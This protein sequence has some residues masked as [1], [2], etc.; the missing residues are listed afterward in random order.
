MKVYTESRFLKQGDL[1]GRDM[2]LTIA[3]VTREDVKDNNGDPK[4]KFILH[5]RETEKGLILNKTNMGILYKLYNSDD[6]DD[7]IGKRMTLYYKDD[8][9][10][11]GEIVGGIR[12]RTKLPL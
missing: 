6:S 2:V 1:D 10:M 9:E 4:K 3:D 5:F 12:I 7:W 11:G 8:V